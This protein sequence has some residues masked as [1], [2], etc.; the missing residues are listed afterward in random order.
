MA[1]KTAKKTVKSKA[2]RL[3]RLRRRQVAAISDKAE[4][5]LER[6]FV[7]KFGRL[8]TVRRFVIGWVALFVLLIG[9]V[10][11]Q[12]R[13][14]GGYY[15]TMQ[16][17]AGGLYSEGIV[18]T[19]SNANPLYATG[20]VND[21]VSKLLFAG[22]CTYDANNKLVGD[23]AESWQ[24]D[25]AGTTYTVKLRPN[26]TWHD[27]RP[28]TA[29]DVVFTYKSIQNPEVQSPLNVSWQNV[30]VSQADSRTVLFKLPNP[31]S[32]F[33]YSLTNG[34]IPKHILGSV[35]PANLR[36][37]SFNTT[38]PVGSG[39]FAFKNV[40]VK[41]GGPGTRQEEI[42]LGSFKGYHGG[43]A[44]LSSFIIRTFP[45]EEY[46][47]S[48]FRD[49][50]VTAMVGL[51]RVPGDLREDDSVQS[52]SMPLTAANMV[53]FKTTAGVLKNKE[54]RQALV[55]AVNMDQIT[56]GLPEP[57]LPVRSPFLQGSSSYNTDF[58]QL[59]SG[60]DKAAALLEQAGW[61]VGPDGVR[62]KDNQPLTFRLYA[63]DAAEYRQVSSRLHD[64][65]RKIGVNAEVILQADS[66]LRTTIYGVGGS[67][68]HSYD[69]LLYGIS[70]GVDP[71]QFVY[72]DGSQADVRS[73]SRLNFSEYNSEVAN[74]ALEAGR[75]R[76]DPALR[77]IK[78]QPFLKAW[79]DDA[80]A[81]GLYQPR[82]LYV[83]HGQV[84]GLRDHTLTAD[85][86][87]FNNVNNWMVR[88]AAKK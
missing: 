72:W 84:Y 15:Q 49:H 10:V 2:W 4:D 74:A 33:P 3:F 61:K 79:Q 53:F 78:Y 8:Q 66:E 39:P 50:T 51:Q 80:P 20:L 42:A 81:L 88:T 27:G 22:L 85:T 58:L 13:A 5:Q 76:S 31:L 14:L 18:G 1:A 19:Y 65:W 28:L 87:R 69:A 75:T 30:T 21:A 16:P 83:V 47:L 67:G 36:S 59:N 40:E 17:V 35:A 25:E 54:V 48:A 56:E 60:P 38:K 23:L 77:A 64:Q 82:F 55:G 86:D 68:D 43:A 41:G 26:I 45:D 32:S 46:L 73:P 7:R 9:I 37:V 71:D 24:A 34:I 11:V 70:L 52:L 12:A 29:E 6:N 62:R 44:K 57:V 63:Q